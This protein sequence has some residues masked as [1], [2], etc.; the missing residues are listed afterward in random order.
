MDLN[1]PDSVQVAIFNSIHG[2]KDRQRIDRR[3]GPSLDGQWCK[4][5]HELIAVQPPRRFD[6]PL[7]VEIL[8]DA[9]AHRFHDHLVNWI[10]GD[11]L[12]GSPAGTGVP[13]ESD[14]NSL[15]IV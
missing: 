13:I 6:G 15:F 4:R 3:A 8:H 2:L 7:E 14:S 11:A 9:D 5:D 1:Q 10:S 12:G